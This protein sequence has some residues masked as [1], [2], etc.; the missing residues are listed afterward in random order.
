MP[1]IDEPIEDKAA[2]SET[3]YCSISLPVGLVARQRHGSMRVGGQAGM[4]S[5]STTPTP[6]GHDVFAAIQ[7]MV[8]VLFKWRFA[9]M[10]CVCLPMTGGSR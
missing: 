7:E 9:G 4:R 6:P 10:L 5:Y 3:A 2:Q 8:R 1:Y